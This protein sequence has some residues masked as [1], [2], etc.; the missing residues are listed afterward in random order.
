MSKHRST[1][2][3]AAAG[4]ALL[5]TTA[6]TA[7]AFAQDANQWQFRASAY[8]YFPDVSSSATLP[9]GAGADIDLEAGDLIEHTDSAFMGTFEAQRGRWGAFVDAMYFNIGNSV[10]ASDQ[11]SVGGGMP[12]PPGVTVDGTFDLKMW[13]LTLAANYRVLQSSNAT[14]D[15]FGGARML[16]VDTSFQ[17]AFNTDFG[18]FSGPLRQGA[19]SASMQNWDAIVGAKGRYA[20][21][22]N[23]RW[24][25][26]YYA[27]IG[28]GDSDLTWQVFGGVG[29]A[30]GP[31]DV[32]VGYRHLA[33]EFASDSSVEDLTFD[34]PVVGVSYN[35]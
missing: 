24:Y 4:A 15:V 25:V 18:P 23:N 2:T 6:T 22:R 12:L 21:G 13:V 20:F 31:V 35:F 33:Y 32:T 1:L 17:Y 27:D 3:F 26:Q 5:C 9:T 34:G 16:D 29:R 19:T 28:A 14:L 7:P 10:N 8:G 30:I 11:I